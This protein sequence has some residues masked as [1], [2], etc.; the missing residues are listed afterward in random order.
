MKFR[1]P[2]SNEE[3]SLQITAS[4][5][6]DTL[7]ALDPNSLQPNSKKDAPTA[8]NTPSREELP[9]EGLGNCVVIMPPQGTGRRLTPVIL[10]SADSESEAAI[11]ERWNPLL[12][13]YH[14]MLLIPR[15]A[16]RTPL[17]A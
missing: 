9:V 7:P 3:K 5:L 11:I 8:A 14:L 1:T 16:G 10:L 17:T 12:A 6:P 13:D 15:T 2:G 4:P